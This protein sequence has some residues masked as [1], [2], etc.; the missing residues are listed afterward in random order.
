MQQQ[1]TKINGYWYNLSSFLFVFIFSILY[2]P[3]LLFARD[4]INTQRV[5]NVNKKEIL[6]LYWPKT[7]N[8]EEKKIKKKEENVS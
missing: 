7:L 2:P 4:L 8:F 5:T 6:L 3:N 1:T